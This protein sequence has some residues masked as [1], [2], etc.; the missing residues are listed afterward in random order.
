[1]TSAEELTLVVAEV[2]RAAMTNGEPTAS[3]TFVAVA[4]A[5]TILERLAHPAHRDAL[6]AGLVEAGVLVHA[7][8][9]ERP[10]VDV[11]AMEEAK[12]RYYRDNS[13]RLVDEANGHPWTQDAVDAMLARARGWHDRR[14]ILDGP[15]VYFEG[16]EMPDGAVPLFRIGGDRG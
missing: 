6:V 5:Q 11:A 15:R 16:D 3:D 2:V 14:R 4:T 7:D 1:V 10:E 8:V 13:Q 12:A 9:W